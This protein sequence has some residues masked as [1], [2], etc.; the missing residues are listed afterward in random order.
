MVDWMAAKM[1]VRWVEK[2]AETMVAHL[3]GNL[4]V[5]LVV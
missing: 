5:P 2:M 3:V 1:V 4:A